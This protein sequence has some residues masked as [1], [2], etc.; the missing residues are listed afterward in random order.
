M[1]EISLSRSLIP[2]VLS[3][4]KTS[5]IRRGRRSYNLGYAEIVSEEIRIPVTI[6]RVTH[7][8]P[9]LLDESVVRSEGYASLSEL[10]TQLRT[11]YPDLSDSNDVTI[12]WFTRR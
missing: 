8:N 10:L 5:T 3:G 11:F 9:K 1:I 2:L 12:V 6:T 7:S 4:K